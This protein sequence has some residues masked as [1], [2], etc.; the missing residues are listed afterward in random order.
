MAIAGSSDFG[1]IS[2]FSTY[3][4][5]KHQYGLG[6]KKT[7]QKNTPREIDLTIAYLKGLN[8]KSFDQSLIWYVNK[9]F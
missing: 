1:K 2:K 4:N 6:I 9:S 8:S 3:T 7:F 5:Q